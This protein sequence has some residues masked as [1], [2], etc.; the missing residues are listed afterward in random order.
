MSFLDIEHYLRLSGRDTWCESGNLTQLMVR[1]LISRVVYDRTPQGSSIPSAYVRFV[2]RLTA[3]DVVF[4]FNYDTLLENTFEYLGR[5][6]RLVFER[7]LS[8]VDGV[9]ESC[10]G[11]D[12]TVVIKLHGSVDWYCD[13]QFNQMQRHVAEN[14]GMYPAGHVHDDPIFGPMPRI[15]SESIVNDW[16]P[17][18]SGLH[19]IRRV[20]DMRA[21]LWIPYWQE[22]PYLLAPS[23]SKLFYARMIRDLWDELPQWGWGN[24]LVSIIGYS[25]PSHDEYARQ[26]IYGIADN[27]YRS[28]RRRV[29]IVDFRPS[30]ADKAAHQEAF[31]FL[32]W[33]RT[34]ARYDGLYDENVDWVF[35][36][37]QNR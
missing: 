14:R 28:T 2:E 10:S 32:R 24:G 34:D 15:Q 13:I 7:H 25:M 6:Y 29:R 26:V 19:R 12:E 30:D 31:R 33:K 1:H 9:S 11:F 35:S 3:S 37:P 4:T 8:P 36:S 18:E 27:Y 5:P 21:A 17:K 23:Q 20:K 22:S 16:Y